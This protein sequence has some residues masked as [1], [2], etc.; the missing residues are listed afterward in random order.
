MT[1]SVVY[2]GNLLNS[3]WFYH[4]LLPA[5][6]FSLLFSVHYARVGPAAAIGPSGLSS[7][8]PASARC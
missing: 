8:F 7:E 5:I 1:Q 3:S 2:V 6:L 4:I